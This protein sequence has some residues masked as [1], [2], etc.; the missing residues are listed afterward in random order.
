MATP[1]LRQR[2]WFV[3]PSFRK[4]RLFPVS[5]WVLINALSFFV[6]ASTLPRLLFHHIVPPASS[7]PPLSPLF[8][9]L[10]HRL[11]S[12]SA[13]A[14]ASSLFSE[15]RIVGISERE[16]WSDR[17]GRNGKPTDSRLNSSYDFG[18]F[19]LSTEDDDPAGDAGAPEDDDEK[20]LQTLGG[21]TKSLAGGEPF[22]GVLSNEE[23]REMV[24]Q[25]YIYP[26]DEHLADPVSA[27][28]LIDGPQFNGS[29]AFASPPYGP[30]AR[31]VPYNRSLSVIPSFSDV[32]RRDFDPPVPEVN[33][34]AQIEDFWRLVENRTT[35]WDF[36]SPP[37]S[38][39]ER[40]ETGV[41]MTPPIFP[42]RVYFFTREDLEDGVYDDPYAD[43]LV[44]SANA[45]YLNPA[46]PMLKTGRR[47]DA[48]RRTDTGQKQKRRWRMD[49]VEDDIPRGNWTM[50]N[51]IY[52]DMLDSIDWEREWP[53]AHDQNY[54]KRSDVATLLGDNDRNDD[55]YWDPQ[56]LGG[57]D[58]YPKAHAGGLNFTW[59]LFWVPWLAKKFPRRGGQ[60]IK[61]EIFNLGGVEPLQL[62]F[63]PDGCESSHPGF[64]AVKL[65]S[66][67]GWNL[68]F[69]IK[70]WI[71]GGT[72]RLP[73]PTSTPNGSN[74]GDAPGGGEKAREETR[75]IKFRSQVTAGPFRREEA[76][77]VAYSFSFCRLLD[78]R[79]FRTSPRPPFPPFCPDA[80]AP[81]APIVFN[82][83]TDV[84]LGAAGDIELGVAVA[85]DSWDWDDG[86]WSLEQWL[87]L[88]S[89]YPDD[90]EIETILPASFT[91]SDMFENYKYRDV[92][93]KHF[94]KYLPPMLPPLN[95]SDDQLEQV[96]SFPRRHGY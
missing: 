21:R 46:S 93:D 92:P 26:P 2:F 43:G 13:F 55:S 86:H 52:K 35:D 64:C 74:E 9:A 83:E 19:P 53:H 85:E 36:F 71:K 51:D 41:V 40:T 28:F 63:Y 89:A 4:K 78:K 70:L 84:V 5:L 12:L 20:L 91:N 66:R 23:L 76:D 42:N 62:W 38:R 47:R 29:S 90:L 72:L 56:F 10:S 50:K 14:R 6:C 39:F 48:H 11:F 75:W 49:D 58:T 94:A 81:S 31:M 15:T 1:S 25:G 18:G 17:R 45:S 88:Q 7:P 77:Y 37:G 65:V 96:Y 27:P 68:P 61:S 32:G 30:M 95:L 44:K 59:P 3:F 73:V 69:P 87:K 54:F 34:T 16:A 67:P 57:V 33:A 82:P 24:R 8:S 60:P 79:S 22:E 80:S